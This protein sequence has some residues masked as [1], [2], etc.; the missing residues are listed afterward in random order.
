MK[1]GRMHRVTTWPRRAA[2]RLL[3]SQTVK[4][5]AYM[6]S[7]KI[8]ATILGFIG[9]VIVIR[10][11]GPVNFGLY[12]TAIAFINLITVTS[13]L[14]LTTATIKFG[15]LYR[16]TG[17][18][19]GDILFSTMCK[20]KL[21]VALVT[22]IGGMLLVEQIA[23]GIYGKSELVFPLRI[24]MVY[25]AMNIITTYFHAILHAREAFRTSASIS[26][27][28]AV[29]KL[30]GILVLYLVVRSVTLENMLYLLLGTALFT[31]FLCGS[32]VDWSFL[33]VRPTAEAERSVRKEAWKF[34]K[35]VMISTFCFPLAKRLDIVMLNYYVDSAFVG[36]YA[37]AVQLSLPLRT[38]KA[39]MHNVL[40]PRISR[41]TSFEGYVTHVGKYTGM[42][43]GQ[44]RNHYSS[45]D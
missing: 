22:S 40:L 35:W 20:L 31:L 18:P 6:F 34:S 44:Y 41:I 7:S 36:I 26:F 33:K 37:C 21:I 10:E 30:L 14:G 3:R 17:N 1:V 23:V 25:I 12:A 19:R 29:V 4:N 13:D 42:T 24:S 8:G 2:S 27:A 45:G 38:L 9:S 28:V 32:C 15:A 16:R 43:P 39:T 11:L 5:T